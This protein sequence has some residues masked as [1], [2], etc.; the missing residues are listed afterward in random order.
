MHSASLDE[1]ENWRSRGREA[2]ICGQSVFYLDEGE[3]EAGTVLLIHGFPTASWDWSRLWPRLLPGHRL[4]ALDL[5]GF[6]F[7]AKPDHRRY[8]IAGQADVVEGLVDQLGLAEFHVLAHDY[9][10]TVAQELLA[11]QN[12]AAGTGRWLSC[13]FLNGGLFPETHRALLTQR[14]LLSPIGPWVNRFSGKGRFERSF[15]RVFGPATGPTAADIDAFWYLINYRNGKHVFHNL[16]TYMSERVEHRGRW[17]GAL[18]QSPVPLA[19]INGSRDPVSGAHMVARYRQLG[20]RL[21]Y[22]AELPEIGHYPQFED[23]ASVAAHY[24]QFLA[25][26]SS[27]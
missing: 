20:C 25:A 13:C 12:A 1:L 21:D 26:V 9:G 5:P 18:E 4:V 7:S 22:L 8:R 10:D 3:D 14:L 2:Q 16:I 27:A 15:S 6:G 23:P 19:L 24:R 11:R 17:V